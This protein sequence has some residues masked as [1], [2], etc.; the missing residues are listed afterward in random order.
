[1]VAGTAVVGIGASAGGLEALRLM[2]AALPVQSGMAF[3]VVQH[4]APDQPSIL[5]ELLQRVTAIPVLQATQGLQLQPDHLYVN[6]PN[7]TLTI[8]NGYCQ[9]SASPKSTA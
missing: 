4:L 3:V 1:M 7:H 5:A 9:L 2:L 8:V 6:T